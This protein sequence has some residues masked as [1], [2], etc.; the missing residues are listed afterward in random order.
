MHL[1]FDARVIQ[2]HFPGIGRYAYNLLAALPAHLDEH[3]RVTALFNPSVRNTRYPE[4]QSGLNDSR[5]KWMEHRI[6][7]FSP[8]NLLS[9]LPRAPRSPLDTPSIPSHYHPSPVSE[10]AVSL[11]KGPPFDLAH[12][13]YYVRP[14]RSARPSITT[15]YDAISFVYPRYVPSA[16]SR[17]LIRLMH[18]LAVLA[19]DGFITISQSAAADL[20]KFFPR[21][22]GRTRV[23]PLAADAMFAPQ[24]TSAQAR[25]CNALNLAQ[26]FAL[27]LASN[28]PHKNLE[29]LVRAW[30][31]ICANERP[32]TLVIAGHQDPRY[33]QAQQLARSLGLQKHV[34]FIGDVPNADLPA[35]YSA[36][37]LFVY[38]SLYEGFGLTPLEAMACGAPVACSNASSLPEV[39]GDAAVL[40]DP[41]DPAALAATCQLLLNDPA[42]LSEMRAQSLRQASRFSWD[43]C[44]RETVALYRDCDRDFPSV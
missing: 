7:L 11:S 14:L 29:G 37:A 42:R 12:F 38:P 34:R 36:C 27:Y 4:F 20:Q 23:T 18:E 41:G 28:K 10:P 33:P 16:K 9:A 15:I 26:P 25:V 44:A 13:T 24:P 30:A 6:T 21:M 39:A 43:R 35:L 2:D 5:I 1:L 31:L 32:F 8:K 17:L 40:F 19:S 22:R 3:D